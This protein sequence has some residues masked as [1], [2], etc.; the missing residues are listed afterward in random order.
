LRQTFAQ[1][2]PDPAMR[3]RLFTM[4][5][6]VNF[7]PTTH[8]QRDDDC[9]G[10]GGVE[11]SNSN[12]QRGTAMSGSRDAVLENYSGAQRGAQMR[13]KP[14]LHLQFFHVVRRTRKSV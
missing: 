3:N 6:T 10:N 2:D 14:I 12:V 13:R 1:Q 11:K 5:G 7:A 4:P 8:S 9:R